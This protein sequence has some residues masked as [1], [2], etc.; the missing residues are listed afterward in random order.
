MKVEVVLLCEDE[1]SACFGRRFLKE[2]GYKAWQL[3]EE[4][5]PPGKGSGEQ[6]VREKMPNELRAMRDA[7]SK[8]LIVMTDADVMG[9]QQRV[10]TLRRKCLDEGVEWR[11]ADEAVLL[12][13]PARNIETWLA[14]L[15]GETV[16][17]TQVYPKYSAESDCRDEVRELVK[18]CR[19]GELREPAPS[20]LVTACDEWKRMP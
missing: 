20:S 6:W 7:Q 14:Y 18:M 15:R 12:M 17:E 5:P 4:K 2:Y 1:Q 3:R 10:E 9:T 16:N 11:K 19:S 8:A 13:I